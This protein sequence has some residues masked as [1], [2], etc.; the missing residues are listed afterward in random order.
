MQYKII[1]AKQKF[2]DLPLTDAQ[3]KIV[4]EFLLDSRSD[5][6]E[7]DGRIIRRA[8]IDYVDE[9]TGIKEKMVWICDCGRRNPMHLWPPENCQCK[10]NRTEYLKKLLTQSL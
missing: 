10:G 2:P 5:R 3:H 6:M 1:F 9:Y 4:K 7:I 8:D